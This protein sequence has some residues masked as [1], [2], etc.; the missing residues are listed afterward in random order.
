MRIA[1]REQAALGLST[2]TAILGKASRV[3]TFNL[4]TRAALTRRQYFAAV[5]GDDAHLRIDGVS[6]LAGASHADTTLVVEHDCQRSESRELIR[7][8]VSDAAH[9]VF[10][11]KVI[12]KPHAQKTDGRMASNAL[13]IGPKAEMANKPELEIF[14]DDVQCAHGATCGEIDERQLFLPPVARHPAR[15]GRGAAHPRLRRRGGG[16]GGRRR[17]ADAGRRDAAGGA[18]G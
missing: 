1:A 11:G 6:L 8:V 3:E 15:R 7:S 12:V 17:A 14:A 10:Q 9:G 5:G 13:L 18:V 16:T 4:G 2:V